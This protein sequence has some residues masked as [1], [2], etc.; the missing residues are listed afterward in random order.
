VAKQRRL[1]EWER[2][3]AAADRVASWPQSVIRERG[4]IRLADFN[5]LRE[6]LDDIDAAEA[7]AELVVERRAN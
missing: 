2:L 3:Y 5:A 4:T 6:A 7:L 1:D